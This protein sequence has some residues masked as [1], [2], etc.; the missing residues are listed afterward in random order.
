[1]VEEKISNKRITIILAMMI[2][3]AGV[4][5]IFVNIPENDEQNDDE[6]SQEDQEE[7]EEETEFTFNLTYGNETKSYTFKELENLE[8]YS[9]NATMIKTR[10]LPDD[11]VTEGPNEFTGI[12]IST[13]LEEIDNLPENYNITSIASDD[14]T[15]DF[16]ISMIQGKVKIYNESGVVVNNSGAEMILAY[17]KDGK[18]L[19]EDEGPI[20][21]VFC[22][23][24]YYT[25]SSLWVKMIETIEIVEL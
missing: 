14:W 15:N 12:R 25:S 19:E 7:N 22:H 20:R 3:I 9:C 17:K 11:V 13:I 5:I 2:I 6:T 18:Y 10:F 4:V 24:Q 23:N 8:S 16:N 1:M 21:I